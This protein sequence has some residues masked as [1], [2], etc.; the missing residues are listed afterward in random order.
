MYKLLSKSECRFCLGGMTLKLLLQS[1]MGL[2]TYVHCCCS[3]WTSINGGVYRGYRRCCLLR[4]SACACAPDLD[5]VQ[6]LQRPRHVHVVLVFSKSWHSLVSPKSVLATD[7]APLITVPVHVTATHCPLAWMLDTPWIRYML[8][9]GP[10]DSSA[11]PP[12]LSVA[13]S[14]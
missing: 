3:F 11:S 2:P 1:F 4:L 13:I 5:W 12:C 7:L 9:S 6:L 10:L 8:G 14:H